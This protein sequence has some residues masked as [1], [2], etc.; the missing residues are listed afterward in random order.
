MTIHTN[1]TQ[2]EINKQLVQAGYENRWSLSDHSYYDCQ[3]WHKGNA[4][5][6][7]PHWACI[8]DASMLPHIND[9]LT[10]NWPGSAWIASKQIARKF[11]Y[12]V[13][14]SYIDNWRAGTLDRAR[15]YNKF[16]IYAFYNLCMHKVEIAKTIEE[17]IK[18][19]SR[20]VIMTIKPNRFA[21]NPIAVINAT[22]Y[23]D[24]NHTWSCRLLKLHTIHGTSVSDE[25]ATPNTK[26]VYVFKV[27]QVN[28]A[29][30]GRT[31]WVAYDGHNKYWDIYY[32]R[33]NPG[34]MQCCS[35]SR[36]K[37]L[38]RRHLAVFR[39]MVAKLHEYGSST[40]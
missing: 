12:I 24:P 11:Q 9:M 20:H 10:R 3:L 33:G 25:I 30:Y 8:P 16:R 1:P 23:I 19:A 37:P 31:R 28:A 36:K 38:E 29:G 18:I 14:P 17:A 27:N 34:A 32:W 5:I 13:S 40:Q 4:V 2:A 35:Y 39:Q 6:R 26:P 21:P 15:K 7:V 22:E